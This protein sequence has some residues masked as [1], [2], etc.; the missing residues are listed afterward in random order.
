M[1]IAS[2]AVG[3]RLILTV[4]DD[5]AGME[6]EALE[7]YNSTVALHDDG[8]HIHIGITNVLRR[9]NMIYRR[10]EQDNGSPA[11]FEN[12]KEGGLR[13]TIDIPLTAGKRDGGEGTDNRPGPSKADL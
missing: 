11:R 7:R 10:E 6:K 3:D 13:I 12:R 9:L 5:G 8:S 1:V 2:R 4:A